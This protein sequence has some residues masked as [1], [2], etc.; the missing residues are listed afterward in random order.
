MGSKEQVE[1]RLCRQEAR[2]AEEMDSS[3][4]GNKAKQGIQA[5]DSSIFCFLSL[6]KAMS[7]EKGKGYEA[8]CVYVE[9]QMEDG[10]EVCLPCV[11]L[12]QWR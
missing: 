7:W 12:G 6:P 4:H 9:G 1:A 10:N 2:T 11:F 8:L 5:C 3:A